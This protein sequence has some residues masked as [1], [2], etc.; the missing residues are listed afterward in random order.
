MTPVPRSDPT[1]TKAHTENP[2][3][4]RYHSNHADFKEP[5]AGL[6]QPLGAACHS[7]TLQAAH[8]FQQACANKS[9]HRCS[10]EKEQ[11]GVFTP[12]SV[13]ERVQLPDLASGTRI[14]SRLYQGKEEAAAAENLALL[15]RL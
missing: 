5:K 13:Q 14:S 4:R 9:R 11:C 10:P 8:L 6:S 2:W 1:V 12:A 15:L 3:G 7:K